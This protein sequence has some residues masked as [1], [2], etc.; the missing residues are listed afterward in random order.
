MRYG[1]S[2]LVLTLCAVAL[3]V[4]PPAEAVDCGVMNPLTNEPLLANLSLVADRS[5]TK[6]Q[7][8]WNKDTDYLMLLYNIEGCEIPEGA[9]LPDANV[10]SLGKHIKTGGIEED[11]KPVREGNRLR[12]RINAYP[13]KF[14]PGKYRVLV[15]VSAPYL[16]EEVTET[17]VS[18]FAD[19][20]YAWVAVIVGAFF[21]FIYLAS[22][23]AAKIKP[24]F[25]VQVYWLLA[26]LAVTI[27]AGAW[28]IFTDYY[29]KSIETWDVPIDAAKTGL[30]AFLAASGGAV[31]AIVARVWRIRRQAKKAGKP[32]PPLPKGGAKDPES[33][34]ITLAFR[35]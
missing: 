12:I 32:K 24:R 22:S 35:D 31:A 28:V 14:D 18:R 9:E 3:I 27:V 1:R 2:L 19:Q 7:F 34:A 15:T 25:K 33:L 4:P 20:W 13:K 29:S 21:A 16:A 6:L 10:E 5:D 23:S 26:A 8:R 17:E 30:D 11:P